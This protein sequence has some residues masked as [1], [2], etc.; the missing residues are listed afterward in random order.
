MTDDLGERLFGRYVADRGYTILGRDVDLG[1]PK[2]PDFHLRHGGDEV[3]VEVKTFNPPRIPPRARGNGPVCRDLKPVRERIGA[4]AKQLRGI[5]GRGLVVVVTSPL[6]PFIPLSP[7]D[8]ME[9]MYGD[10]SVDFNDGPGHDAYLGRNAKLRIDEPDGTAHGDHGYL[11]AVAVMRCA[12]AADRK[13]AVWMRDHVGSYSTDLAAFTAGLDHIE[14]QTG[15]ISDVV[16]LDVFETV[17][18]AAHPLPR[19][20]FTGPLDGRWGL[21]ARGRY[22]PLESPLAGGSTGGRW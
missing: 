21:T 1:T 9:A 4:G 7:M 20:I 10:L 14:R 18:V 5:T 16:C 2:R 11:S 6:D 22:G 13:L 8:M 19:A 12:P 15:D 17:S 3:V